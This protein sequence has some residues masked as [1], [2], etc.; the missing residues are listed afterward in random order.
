MDATKFLEDFHD[1]LAPRL[2]T[3]EQ[4][5]YL[6]LIRHSRLKGV[7]QT[8][9]GFKSAR[10]RMAVGIGKSGSPFSERICY[11]RSR[12]LQDKGCIRIIGTEHTGTRYEIYLPHEIPGVVK[13]PESSYSLSLEDLDFFAVPENRERILRRE[14]AKCFYCLRSLTGDNFVIEHVISRPAGDNTYRNVVAACR[15]CNNRKGPAN[16]DDYLRTLYRDGL[17]S[18]EDFED[19]LTHLEQ[20]QDG[21]LKP[22]V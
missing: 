9:I 14:S 17:L 12:S 7:R 10:T 11:E 8:V 22:P 4:A 13:S 20:L 2:D 15:Q 18:R 6:F 21:T 3:Y 1:Y 19:R 16:A 5:I